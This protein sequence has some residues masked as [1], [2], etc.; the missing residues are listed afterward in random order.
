MIRHPMDLSTVRKKLRGGHYVIPNDIISDMRLV[1][2]N[3]RTYNS[4]GTQVY[5]LVNVA[6]IE[7]I[8]S[9]YGVNLMSLMK[10]L[11]D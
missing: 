4:K 3:A 1:F 11:C 10:H 9:I 2:S 6:S 5:R 8:C 7:L